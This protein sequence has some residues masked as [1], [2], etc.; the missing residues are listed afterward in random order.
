MTV[1]V[2]WATISK[3]SQ[4][5]EMPMDVTKDVYLPF[6]F[7]HSCQEPAGIHD[8]MQPW[9][10]LWPSPVHVKASQVSPVVA[11]NHTVRVQH[12]YDVNYVFLSQ[13]LCFIVIAEKESQ[14][15]FQG[16]GGLDLAW[17][18]S[19]S[20]KHCFLAV[21]GQQVLLVLA[22]NANFMLR[23]FWPR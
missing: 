16:V 12:G 13:L 3:A 23:I 21:V 18:Y 5:L 6:F 22:L 15:A 2:V 7:H 1:L 14:H 8:W 11:M 4:W 19:W 9:R 17:M 20:D 10:R